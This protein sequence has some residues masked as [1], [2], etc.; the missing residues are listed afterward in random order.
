MTKTYS[1]LS[2]SNPSFV[3]KLY[4]QYKEAP[5]SLDEKWS[6]FFEGYEL[7]ATVRQTANNLAKRN[8]A[9]TGESKD[10]ELR[11]GAIIS[12]NGLSGHAEKE[13]AVTKLIQ[14]YR[15][16]G[17]LAA[18]INPLSPQDENS[19]KKADLE[20][21]YFHLSEKDFETVF[22][23][24]KELKIGAAK[25]KTILKC[26]HASY[27]S[28]MGIEFI[29]CDNSAL[30]KWIYNKIEPRY[31]SPGY[32]N[33]R[34]VRIYKHLSAAV[35]F[36]Q[37][38]QTKY[39]GQKRFGLEGGEALIPALEALIVEGSYRGVQEFVFG[40]AHRG[41]LNV[42]V[43]ILRKSYS[44]IFTEF[45]G[46][47]LPDSIKGDGDVKYHLG[48]SADI[49]KNGRNVHLSLA[50][51][52]SH[53]EAVTP[54]TCGMVY[55]KCMKYYKKDLSKI[56]NISIHGDASVAGQGVVYELNNMSKLE[57]Y[58]IG[59]T[60]HL[61]IDN[62][63]GFTATGKETRSG[64][65]STDIA[66]LLGSPIFHV[67]A[68]DPI[69]MAYALELAIGI[70]QEFAIDV[71]VNMISYRRRGHNEGDEPRF[72]QPRMYSKIDAHDNVLDIFEKQLLGESSLTA[73]DAAK[74]KE[75][76]KHI[77]EETL[78][79]AKKQKSHVN[80]DSLRRYWQ[81]IRIARPDDFERPV[82]TSIPKKKLEELATKI[83]NIPKEFPAHKKIRAL[84]EKRMTSFK[85]GHADWAM[86]ESLAFA[87][88]LSERRSV[89][90]SG[91]DSV[92]GTFSHRHARL[93]ALVNGKE[94]V[95]VP[96]NSC[97]TGLAHYR[98][99]NSQLSE[100]SVLGFEYGYSLA[101]PHALTIWEAQFGDF[102]NCAQVIIDQFITSGESK[103]QRYSGIV[104]LLP[105]GYE[106]MG[107]EHS[108]ARIERY[109]QMC[110][111]KNMYVSYPTTP[112]NM[113]HLLRRQVVAAF[114]K[115]SIVMTPKSMLRNS[116]VV[117]PLPDF[118]D[119]EFE[120]VIDDSSA[121]AAKIK[122]VILCTGKV[123]Y[124]LHAKRLSL[125]RD[126]VALVRIEQLYPLIIS[127]IKAIQKKYKAA[128]DW[129]WVQEEPENMGAWS[130]LAAKL[131]FLKLR[132]ISRK[133]AASPASGILAVHKENQKTILENAFK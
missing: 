67:N 64:V 87:S 120:E 58:N 83:F 122:R 84:F 2:N 57:G 80:V 90:V 11:V 117:S 132:V 93:Y 36:E 72:T 26:L 81:D 55:A 118:F 35:L 38:L 70:R 101:R 40:M 115:P 110:A 37:F 4:Q 5:E 109:L 63:I 108:S 12:N 42:L 46:G 116:Y 123:Y 60:V 91:Q 50:F 27:I 129:L 124:D 112:A 24:G 48:Q 13:I 104:L 95:Y 41:R 52:P 51:N 54:I 106:G 62:Q 75:K 43:N 28:K 100:F 94:Q 130:F 6:I 39:V 125:K 32:S 65:Y 49:L 73:Q 44:D 121:T 127:Q 47:T 105:H 126:D 99:I 96:L 1:Y 56:V 69:K 82:A 98:V 76:Y 111:D 68:D 103:W 14:A 7:E 8:G 33:E 78:D 45:E 9:G 133:H 102:A 17:H 119:G 59:G 85:N 23:A 10:S 92:R 89:R 77:L 16:R 19:L 18:D 29:H 113:F 61:V 53:L 3:E 107:P 74:I 88:I 71:W 131:D 25:L 66:R 30:R 20:L 34:K 22:E 97:L 114:R 15:A 86:A 21:S 128:K 79:V 31:G